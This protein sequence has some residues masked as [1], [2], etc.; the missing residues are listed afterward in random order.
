MKPFYRYARF[1][2][3]A[4]S[5]GITSAVALFAGIFGGMWLDNRLGTSPTFLIIGVFLGIGLIF[6]YLMTEVA[7][8]TKMEQKV[9]EEREKEKRKETEEQ[10]RDKD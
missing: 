9:K 8:L 10:E 2:N 1:I 3:F 5:F 7:S 4:L 6:K